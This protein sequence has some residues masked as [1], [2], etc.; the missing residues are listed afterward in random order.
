MDIKT[1]IKKGCKYL[2]DKEFRFLVN[3]K[4]GLY[5]KMADEK[6]L[7]KMFKIRMQQDLDL[8]NPKTFNEKLQWLKLHDRKPEYTTMVDK[9]KVREYIAKTIGEDY[10]IPLLGVYNNADEIDFDKLPNKFVLKC[11][12][13]SGGLCICK[14][15]SKLNIEKVKKDLNKALKEDY[16]LT[17][18]EWPYKNVE[19]K[20]ICEQYME[21]DDT[22]ELRDYKFMCFD[23]KVE[24][25]FVCSERF[26]DDGLKITFFDKD[27]NVLPFTRHYPKS[28]IKIEKPKNYYK[29]IK[30]AE[31]LSQNI[32]F[33]RVDFYEINGK[34]YFGELTFYPGSGIEAFE[35]KEWDYKFGELI[36]LQIDKK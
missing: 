24:F 25:S 3:S 20:I 7:K 14:D 15:K 11:N 31:G 5:N 32:P 17:S 13:N 22:Q 23:G 1:L 4:L 34:I 36:D 35:P 26:S 33:V 21:D 18:R 28:K 9:Y 6:Y 16:Y 8:I 30:L 12:H 19:R 27:W 2:K 10:L 29:M